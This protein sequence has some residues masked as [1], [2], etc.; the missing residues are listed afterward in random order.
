[1]RHRLL[2]IL[3][4]V[5]GRHRFLGILATVAGRYRFLR[6]T[7]TVAGRHRFLRFTATVA[8]R[9]RFLRTLAAFAGT[10]AALTLA[11]LALATL[12]AAGSSGSPAE[13]SP[14][15]SSGSSGNSANNG[16]GSSCPSSNPPTEMQL[17]AGSPQSALLG[18]EF[19]TSLQV[20]LVSSNGCTVTGVAGTA[21][22]F[23]APASGA[24]G[25]FAGSG[26]GAVTV[27]ANAQGQATAPTF[28]ANLLAGSYTVT[29][30]SA[31][32]SV[33]FALS[34]SPAGAPAKLMAVSPLKA[35]AR[36]LARYA[37]P[38]EVR[39]LDASGAPLGSVSI[40]FTIGAAS[41]TNA[42]DAT[43]NAGAT[44]VGSATQ[45]TA[46]TNEAGIATSPSLIAGTSAGSFNVSA[47]LAASAGGG[48]SS[49]SASAS[50]ATASSALAP[51]TFSLK[52]TPGK[53]FKL[54]AG[55]GASQSAALG[56]RFAI[57]L[58]VTVT[59]MQKNP[60]PGALVTFTAPSSGAS[61]SFRSHARRVRVRSNACGIAVAPAFSANRSA[62]GYV[63]RASL[64]HLRA[65]FGLINRS[66]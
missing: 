38:L 40:S 18:S 23:S 19:A 56:E 53:P 5:A 52:N 33:S 43:Q 66:G 44:F 39:V 65:A 62:G 60:S 7:A 8:G 46:T 26:T 6:F 35:S 63:V 14:S 4:T 28:S 17:I 57:P 1:V 48:S 2:R 49:P 45:A 10:L 37:K 20:A 36:V 47:A 9:H 61:G 29:A 32:G 34:N 58:A 15:G 27:G 11:M 24:S 21:V 64:A 13:G 59:D 55:V 42:C 51:L 3:A 41:G 30:V 25:T 54:S 12:P 31:Y 22:R 16:N 50:A